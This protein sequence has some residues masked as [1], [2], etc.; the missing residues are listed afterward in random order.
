LKGLS[1]IKRLFGRRHKVALPSR[2]SFE[3]TFEESRAMWRQRW[4]GAL[5]YFADEDTQRRWLDRSE[6]NPYYSY[7]ECM[8]GYFDD[9]FFSGHEIERWVP[10][11]YMSDEEYRVMLP[12]HRLAEQYSPPNDDA[13]NCDSILA[14]SRWAEVVDAA[15]DAQAALAEL[16]SEPNEL[17]ALKRET[18]WVALKGGGFRRGGGAFIIPA[19]D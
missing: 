2:D 12:F 14:D 13:Y 8:C 15:R 4:L 11:G 16:I 19:A 10:Y 9:T 7:V 6:R 18:E 1:L 17:N 3:P 5:R